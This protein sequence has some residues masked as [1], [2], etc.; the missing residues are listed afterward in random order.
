MPIQQIRLQQIINLSS[1]AIVATD[2]TGEFS[3]IVLAA[4]QLIRRNSANTAFE[5]F[6]IG[7]LATLNSVNNSNWSGTAL[8]IANGGSGQT[9]ANTALN[10]F[11]P[12]QTSN[13][14]KFLT[15][16]GTNTSWGTISTGIT[17][18][19]TAITSGTNNYLLYQASGVVSQSQR[20]Q[21]DGTDLFLINPTSATGGTPKVASPYLYLFGQ[22]YRT[23]LSATQDAKSRVSI[24]PAVSQYAHVPHNDFIIES[25][26]PGGSEWVKV[27]QI[28]T[29]TTDYLVTELTLRNSAVSA[30]G[31][32]IAIGYTGT[33]SFKDL[34]GNLAPIAGKFLGDNPE[35]FPTL[36]F[37]QD[38]PYGISLNAYLNNRIRFAAG[39]PGTGAAASG[40]EFVQS[41]LPVTI[42]GTSVPAGYMLEVIGEA[43]FTSAISAPATTSAGLS[44]QQDN[45]A[46][47][48]KSLF[49]RL[50]A[51]SNFD[52]T[53][54][55]YTSMKD[56]E[57]HILSNVGTADITIKN[58]SGS[59]T[60]TNRF[61]IGTDIVLLAERCI[62]V[63][64]DSTSTRWRILET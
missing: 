64:Y 28:G 8:S 14:G 23:D 2:N 50:N 32:Q 56:G 6:N 39:Y 58:N 19:S 18:N 5:A 16:D 29:K 11:L 42:G 43:R 57:I 17:I 53:G 1:D 20:M 15:T 31:G 63:I 36:S 30:W 37:L 34:S 12:T 59:S 24:K 22:N 25:W 46:P 3:A 48:T 54:L 27:L 9:T 4:N 62:A 49:V 47:A 26:S 51:T 35:G 40:S 33:F 13:S 21:F 44:T 61:L 7:S 41:D 52:L 10:A 38:A 60:S 55:T 45:Y